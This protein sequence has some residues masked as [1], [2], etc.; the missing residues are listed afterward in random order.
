MKT[1]MQLVGIAAVLVSIA[2]CSSNPPPEADYP[3]SPTFESNVGDPAPASDIPE[4]AMTPDPAPTPTQETTPTDPMPMP[5]APPPAMCGGLSDVATIVAKE[6]PGGLVLEVKARDPESVASLDQKMTDLQ[7]GL[8]AVKAP[9]P[10]ANPGGAAEPADTTTLGDCPLVDLKQG[11]ANILVQKQKADYK[12]II[13]PKTQKDKEMVVSTA[14]KLATE[15]F[16]PKPASG[17][18]APAGT[19]P[20]ATPTPTSPTPVGPTPLPTK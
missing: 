7:T 9:A 17:G 1:N 20:A 4:A 10:G 11:S 19:T 18:A 8:K 3:P 5:A 13:Q 16:E 14:A 6:I 15:P 2:A 12:V